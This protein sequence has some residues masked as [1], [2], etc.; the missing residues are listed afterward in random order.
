MAM[1]H[2]RDKRIFKTARAAWMDIARR[3]G[4]KPNQV[5]SAHTSTKWVW[6]RRR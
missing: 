3:T 6:I 2:T 1:I 4:L 5:K